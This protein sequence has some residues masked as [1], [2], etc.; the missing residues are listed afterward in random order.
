MFWNFISSLP[1]KRGGSLSFLIAT[2]R[3]GLAMEIGR[4]WISSIIFHGLFH[5]QWFKVRGDCSFCWYWW[6]CWP[7]LFKRGLSSWSY[8]S[9]IYKYLCNQYLSPLKLWVRIPLGQGVFDTTLCD[10][11]CKWLEAGRWISPGTLV[12]STNITDCRNITEILLKVTLNSI[13]L[14][15]NPQAIFFL[16][17]AYI[18]KL[19]L[20]L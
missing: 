4:T 11:V 19:G 20:I 15:P 3:N 12:S 14:T 9:W 17:N 5:I 8:G 16:Q 10:K 18:K 2:I 7:S 6:N 1:V 13:T